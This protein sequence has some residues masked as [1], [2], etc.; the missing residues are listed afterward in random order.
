MALGTGCL[1]IRMGATLT[2]PGLGHRPACQYHSRPS[3]L[4]TFATAG[5]GKDIGRK[6][7]LSSWKLLM[8][9]GGSE[10][11]SVDGVGGNQKKPRYF[12]GVFAGE[13]VINV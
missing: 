4:R 5:S 12:E 9:G 6:C 3:K 2:S 8:G 10:P 13:G 11:S 7:V 1:E